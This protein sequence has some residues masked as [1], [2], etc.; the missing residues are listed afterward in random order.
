[1]KLSPFVKWVGG[2]G[3][4]ADRLS[5]RK[6]EKFNDYYEPFVGAGAFL[7]HL[8][9]S[10]GIYINDINREL[11]N[12]YEVIRDRPEEFIKKINALDTL[13][14]D[15]VL[16]NA[17]RGEYNDKILN[18][19]HDV[20]MAV[21]FVFLNK[22]CFNGLYRVNQKGFFN[23]PWNKRTT[24]SSI[25]EENIRNVSKFLSAV[26]VSNVDFEEVCENC[27]EGDFVFLDSPYDPLSK[28]ASFTD[29]SKEAFKKEDH[30]RLAEMFA[31][32]TDRGV[33]AMATN[34]NTPLIRELYKDYN[35]EVV[36]VRRSINSKASKRV[37][38]E[39]IITNY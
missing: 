14:R 11:I 19:E 4:L 38:K 31:K 1:M 25:E 21:L 7:F 34:H 27:R 18:E 26:S 6:P 3:Q 37:G 8:Q 22:N 16:Y 29:Y 12:T 17:K 10:N 13:N 15:R 20:D 23:V 35:I 36:D 32:L 9:P 30:I 2:K 39:V 28:T 33:Y 5:D 24:G